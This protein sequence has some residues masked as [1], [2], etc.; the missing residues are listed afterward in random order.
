MVVDHQREEEYSEKEEK[1]WQ[2]IQNL[3]VKYVENME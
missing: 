3:Y 2:N 1:I